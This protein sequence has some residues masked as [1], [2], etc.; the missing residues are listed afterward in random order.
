MRQQ[1]FEKLLKN[2]LTPLFINI[3]NSKKNSLKKVFGFL[4]AHLRVRPPHLDRNVNIRGSISLNSS[5]FTF[6][7]IRRSAIHRNTIRLLRVT[8]ENDM[9]KIADRHAIVARIIEF[10]DTVIL[11]P[12]YSAK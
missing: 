10:K 3:Q 1:I 4:C 12:Y 6:W 7:L 8:R 5:S 9:T 11:F 2:V